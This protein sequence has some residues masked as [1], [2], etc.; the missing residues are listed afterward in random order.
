MPIYMPQS[1]Q[2]KEGVGQMVPA[3][4]LQ[5]NRLNLYRQNLSIPP[6]VAVVGAYIDPNLLHDNNQVITESL[7]NKKLMSGRGGDLPKKSTI[8]SMPDFLT[9]FSGEGKKRV[10]QTT[11]QV[12]PTDDAPLTLE[13]KPIAANR[14]TNFY[15]ELFGAMLILSLPES[16]FKEL[17]QKS[18]GIVVFS[19][20]DPTHQTLLGGNSLF[21]KVELN[22]DTNKYTY[23]LLDTVFNKTPTG[24]YVHWDATNEKISQEI[25]QTPLVGIAAI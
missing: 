18:S 20:F 1:N 3:P 17:A 12:K 7:A 6:S 24:T 10:V 13:S 19:G 15:G 25:Q 4:G 23:A 16:F 21:Y 5:I 11:F 9:N 2:L 8:D 14:Y 22:Q